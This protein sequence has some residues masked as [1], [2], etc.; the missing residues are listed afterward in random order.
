MKTHQWPSW[1]TCRWKP[2]CYSTQN[3]SRPLNPTNLPH[4][5]YIAHI[6]DISILPL[7]NQLAHSE[8]ECPKLFHQ[9]RAGGLP[10][11]P[12]FW[13]ICWSSPPIFGGAF[14]DLSKITECKY[15][16]PRKIFGT[17]TCVQSTLSSFGLSGLRSFDDTTKNHYIS[18]VTCHLRGVK[19][20][21][22]S[23]NQSKAMYISHI[24]LS[25]FTL[26]TSFPQSL[27][28]WPLTKDSL[29]TD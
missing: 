8:W 9:D 24:Y 26:F 12:I 4:C 16:P 10:C 21:E 17:D 13:A 18:N 23:W 29:S 14:R 2:C 20:R 7:S 1:E 28:M 11:P 15:L 25:I 3:S 5:M 19:S 22:T 6:F 27:S